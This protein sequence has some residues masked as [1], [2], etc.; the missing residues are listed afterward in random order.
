MY[1]V[2]I[3]NGDIE[4]WIKNIEQLISKHE[5]NEKKLQELKNIKEMLN[6]LIKINKQINGFYDQKRE[7]KQSINSLEN[8]I[9]Q[10]DKEYFGILCLGF[11]SNYRVK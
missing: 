1:N 6:E 9:F 8:K 4:E 10:L 7:I 3:K 2:Y 11:L 5:K